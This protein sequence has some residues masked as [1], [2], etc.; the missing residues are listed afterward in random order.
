[1]LVIGKA[2]RWESKERKGVKVLE[3]DLT[4]V[5]RMTIRSDEM[6]KL[7]KEQGQD[8]ALRSKNKEEEKADQ[9]WLAWSREKGHDSMLIN[10]E[11]EGIQGEE[12]RDQFLVV[13]HEDRKMAKRR[14][15]ISVGQHGARSRGKIWRWSAGRNKGFK[16]KEK[17]IDSWSSGMK[18]EKW[19][20][21]EGRSVLVGRKEEGIQGECEGG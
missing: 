11:E 5:D 8:L 19:R 15:L 4:A 13:R 17:E 12:K 10:R 18:I 2:E 21:R 1:M 6:S 20:R 14:M 9:C 7:D 16:E 3:E